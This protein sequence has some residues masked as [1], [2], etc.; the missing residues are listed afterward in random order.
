VVLT[1]NLVRGM[2]C[3]MLDDLWRLPCITSEVSILSDGIDIDELE[4]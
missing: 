3:V 4:L 1:G 2:P